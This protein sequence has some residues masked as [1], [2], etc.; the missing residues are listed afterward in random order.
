MS[1]ISSEVLDEFQTILTYLKNH[2]IGNVHVKEIDL[3]RR[4][5]RRGGLSKD[6]KKLLKQSP[7]VF[8]KR[9]RTGMG[10]GNHYRLRT[11]HVPTVN[12]Y[13]SHQTSYDEKRK[14]I[15]ESMKRK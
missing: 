1:E 13:C 11:E 8:I 10:M 7:W 5:R 15:A 12:T 14:L 6:C 3:F 9:Q 4:F 2:A